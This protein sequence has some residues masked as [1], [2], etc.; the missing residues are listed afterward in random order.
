MH[1]TF[2]VNVKS[3]SPARSER[4][5][6]HAKEYVSAALRLMPAALRLSVSRC[7]WPPGRTL[8]TPA[9]GPGSLDPQVCWKSVKYPSAVLDAKTVPS[10]ERWAEI[11]GNV[12]SEARG[13][14]ITGMARPRR[15]CGGCWGGPAGAGGISEIDCS[16]TWLSSFLPWMPPSSPSPRWS[17]SKMSSWRSKAASE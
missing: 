9:P 5:S 2:V 8:A 6:K 16:G 7:I 17:S 4:S 14:G 3:R 12:S 15:G 13:G 10:L 11:G 1:I